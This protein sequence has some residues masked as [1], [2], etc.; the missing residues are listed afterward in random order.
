MARTK[1]RSSRNIEYFTGRERFRSNA[2][3]QGRFSDSG[4]TLLGLEPLEARRLLAVAVDWIYQFGA[5]EDATDYAE[6]VDAA[7]NVYIAGT[8]WGTVPGGTLP[9]SQ[10]AGSAD[11]FVAKFDSEGAFVWARQFGTP[12]GDRAL[13][14]VAD[15]TQIYVAGYSNGVSTGLPQ[16]G[17][18]A[19]GF[20]TCL[21]TDGTELWT[22]T[23]GEEY[24][25][26]FGDAATCIALDDCAVYLG[27][28]TTRYYDEGEAPW[29]YPY[30][31]YGKAVIAKYDLDGTRLWT[32][33]FGAYA[34]TD[35]LTAIN[36]NGGNI[37]AVGN[38]NGLL[39]DNP[40][41]L[42][43]KDFVAKLD[44]SGAVVWA[45]QFGTDDASKTYTNAVAAD[46]TG[47]Y[48]AG[49][50]NGPLF[51]QTHLG[52]SD[53]YLVKF[54][55]DGNEVWTR[56]F[57]NEDHQSGAA[58]AVESGTVYVSGYTNGALPGNESQGMSDAFVASF[59]S[60]GNSQ[61]T[62]QFGS[63]GSDSPRGI[64]VDGSAIYVA[65]S[66]STPSAGDAFLTK[67]TL[68]GAPLWTEHFGGLRNASNVATAIDADGFIYVAGTTTGAFAG[69][70]SAGD[71]D[72]FVTKFDASG[73]EVW[74]MQ[75]GTSEYDVATGVIVGADGV[76]VCGV[77]YGALLNHS[78]MSLS[79]RPDG[80]LA[81]LDE[82]DGHVLWSDQF[83]V[84]T[85]TRVTGV[86]ENALGVYVTGW[87][88]NVAFVTKYDFE[89]DDVWTESLGSS[90]DVEAYG[91]TTSGNSVYITGRLRG[92][93]PGY[94]S[95]GG[96]DAFV[97][98][99]DDLGTSSA[100]AWN[101]QFGTSYSD[102][103][104]RITTHGSNVYIAGDTAGAF[105]GA[106]LLGV[107]DFFAARLDTAGQIDWIEQFGTTATE[108]MQYG[109]I[110]A[111]DSGLY[112]SS[113][114]NNVALPG[115]TS[116]GGQDGALVKFDVDGDILWM[117]QYGTPGADRGY[118]VSVDNGAIL[119]VGATSDVLPGATVV[120]AGNIFLAN[121]VEITNDNLE[122]VVAEAPAGAEVEVTADPTTVSSWVATVEALPERTV[123]DPETENVVIVLEL[124]E[125][126]YD[127]VEEVT[128]PA[129]HTLVVRDLY[130]GS[131]TFVGQSPAFTLVSGKV[132]VEGGVRF[133]NSTDAPTIL[134]KGGSL[135][136]RG[137]TIEESTGGD[138]AAVEILGG[139]V[140]LGTPLDPGGNKLI[141]NGAGR[142]VDN[143]S[144]TAVLAVGNVYRE[145][146][147]PIFT[148]EDPV[149]FGTPGADDIEYRPGTNPAETVV[150][151][152]GMVTTIYGAGRLVA[153]ANDGDDSLQL[154]GSIDLPA[155]FY[156]QGGND[157]IRGGAG[158]DM[159]DGGPGDD[160]IVG[161]SG[162]DF[163]VGG[164]GVDRIVG[165]ADDDMLFAGL[166]LFG[167]E[168]VDQVM[169]RWSGAGDAAARRALV[170]GYIAAEEL[171]VADDDA[172]D[173][174]TGSSGIDW[175]FANLD[176][177]GVL[178][179]VTDLD[180]EVFA[181]DLDFILG[182]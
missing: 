114:V 19:E 9:A 49:Q 138:Q 167:A 122:T 47:I 58:V 35:Q 75:L 3:R 164:L 30:D 4:S 22:N 158:D 181:S 44:A 173:L 32:S 92:T 24:S 135:T 48:V 162:R 7:G 99:I 115:E 39:P 36:V 17:S 65:G 178:D 149:V 128:V 11:A 13:G 131:A 55:Q 146:E 161:K 54:D 163:L 151:F 94:T 152:N 95:A 126:T 97:A 64:A 26:W 130:G 150:E 46:A 113:C 143:H 100:L 156:G 82:Y 98:R 81:K 159:L 176:G 174:L 76:Y 134:V 6:A 31:V 182:V 71:R 66:I 157:R 136:L 166:P 45:K 169:N 79:G 132:I 52:G 118:G 119:V 84:E 20:I 69:H 117:E 105:A 107:Q 74:A 61:W 171:V 63:A 160:L 145:D 155:W 8:T 102:S 121:F 16:D 154:A 88:E 106:V 68:A 38:T 177:D 110:D 43:R 124:R 141:V 170:N 96:Y 83:G 137:A 1:Q 62:S 139:T 28:Y 104:Y 133:M 179:K 23:F 10:N 72:A 5:F 85:G 18:E 57:G 125:G 77:T 14:V 90:N 147:V 15:G 33:E 21:D 12:S 53:A 129:G 127:I 111:D 153:Y 112:L 120:G 87:Q 123:T 108:F 109:G 91:I 70:T 56:Q 25:E 78:K 73:N 59:D 89:G 86:E 37:Y 2:F 180:D 148:S 175:F 172:R 165:N 142:Y 42:Y 116:F 144:A 93:L 140:D 103:A 51:G 34:A 29:S 60:S 101:Q 80:F 67:L 50:T 27:G 168:A 40:T 41:A